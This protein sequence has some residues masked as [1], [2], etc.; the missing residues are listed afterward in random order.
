MLLFLINLDV[1]KK[2]PN[3][4]IDNK[5]SIKHLNF[6]FYSKKY[7]LWKFIKNYEDKNHYFNITYFNYSYS[8]KYNIVKVE[9]NINFYD[10]NNNIKPS[11]LTLYFNLHILC[12]VSQF[13]NNTNIESLANIYNDQ[14]YNCIEFININNKLEF[15]IIINHQ[16]NNKLY[17]VSLFNDKIIN[18]N[19]LNNKYIDNFPL[20]INKKTKNLTQKLQNINETNEN[21]KLTKS[22]FSS[23]EKALVNINNWQFINVNNHYF[24]SCKGSECIYNEIPELCKFD[25]YLTIIDN[26]KNVYN[27]TD[28][29]LAD[30]I[31][32]NYSS[33]DTYP[34]FEE[35][36]KLNLSAHYMT[37]KIDIYN[38][39][40]KNKKKCLSIILVN[41]QNRVINGNFLEKYLTL[42]LKLKA[43]ISGARFICTKN[44]FYN[45]D[46]ITHIC[47]GHGIAI[48]KEFL[49]SNNKYYGYKRYNKILLPPSKKIISIAKKH[50]WSDDNI[51]KI[52]LPKWDKYNN[53]NEKFSFIKEKIKRNSIFIMFTWRQ[54]RPHKK[55]SSYYIKNI[56]KLINDHKLNKALIKKNITLYFT[57]HHNI[58]KLKE[59]FKMSK[60]VKYIFENDIFECLSK[61]NLVVTDFSSI[62]F[63]MICRGK[64]YIIFIPDANDPQ[65][66]KIYINNYYM[67]IKLFKQKSINFL[68][69]Y[70]DLKETIKK[71]IYYINNDFKLEEKIKKF[72][73]SFSFRAGNNTKEFIE[74]LENL[75]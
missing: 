73:R 14:Y 75:K 49:Y 24:C 6:D 56:L 11:D 44:L 70:F 13:K 20:I 65:I 66:K 5:N 23:K 42:L 52:N 68:N 32:V 48:L 69:Q 38:K 64:P 33:D 63:D 74:Y 40:C 31:Y 57:L 2:T 53:Y 10:K 28:Y 61:T 36:I 58:K 8:F 50:G 30:F 46:Y 59:K 54:I 22:F 37:E 4:I 21:I 71:I 19:D 29:L 51:I 27:K 60:Y 72:Y 3:K 55:I 39:Y 25:F 9:Y 7:Y 43:T 34:I 47:V 16:L 62:L 18:Y 45:I 17:T 67:T 1:F 41:R 35:M 15:G 12:H 26:N